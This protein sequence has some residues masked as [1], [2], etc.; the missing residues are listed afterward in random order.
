MAKPAIVHMDYETYSEADLPSLGAFRYSADPS[1]D[2][3]MIGLGLN[4]EPPVIWLPPEHETL[5]MRSSPKADKIFEIM[6]DPETQVYAHNAQFEQAISK[7]HFERLTGYKAPRLE[8]WRCTAAMSRKAALPHRLATVGAKLGLPQQKDKRGAELMKIFSWPDTKGKRTFPRDKP[9]LFEEY[10]NYCLQDVRTER[11]VHHALSEAFEL[12]GLSLEV[13][14]MDS[15]LNDRGFPV[16]VQALRHAQKIID[17]ATPALVERF[18]E[19]TGLNPTQTVKLKKWLVSRGYAGKNLKADTIDA[20]LDELEDEDL[21]AT[22]DPDMREVLEIRKQIGLTSV[23]KVRVML[24][25]VTGTVVPNETRIRGTLIYHGATTGRW[26]GVRVQPHNFMRPKIKN[27]EEVYQAICD[28]AGVDELEICFGKALPMLASCIRHFIQDVGNTMWSVDYSNIEA[29]IVCWLAGQQDALDEFAANVDRYV[30]MAS[31]IFSKPKHLINDH[32][33]RFVGKQAVL[34]CGFG[35]GPPK[36][37][38]TCENYGYILP[39]GLEF[40]AVEAFRKQ[41]AKVK[42]LWYDTERAAKQAITHEGRTFKAGKLAFFSM[43]TAN[44]KFLFMKLPSGRLLAYPDARIKDGTIYFYGN[45]KD[46]IWGD[47]TTYGGKLVENGTQATAADIMGFG[48]IRAE[49]EGYLAASLIHDEFLGY[50][51]PGQTVDRLEFLLTR[52]PHW[53]AGLP[54]AAKGKEVKYYTKL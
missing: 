34:G 43:Q 52:L 51:E 11:E 20:E 37:R 45:I 53:A 44:M 28:G 49:R 4:D 48:A 16:N 25:S 33:E 22:V 5:L 10:V 38:A 39:E 27:T 8:Q 32:P 3:L 17:D 47:V 35:M 2:V 1:T 54:L 19:I 40:K 36:F 24:A 6:R 50:K 21:A 12:R 30:I 9:E 13:F 41:H 29:R 14:Q 15:R 42:Q 31:V 7:Y 23:S 18:R 46:N 26:T